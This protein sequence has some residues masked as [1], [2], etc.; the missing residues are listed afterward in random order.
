MIKRIIGLLLCLTLV[1]IPGFVGEL[2]PRS[3][4]NEGYALYFL[5][6]EYE[7]A[8]G[9][10]ALAAERVKVGGEDTQA[11]AEALIQKLLEGPT[12]EGLKR[13]IPSGTSLLSLELQGRRA[14]V[15]LSG[16]YG[17]LSG[18]ALTLADYAITLTLTQL[19]DIQAVEITVRGHEL[20]YREQQIFTA[21]DVLLDPEEDV[22]GTVTV[23][24][25]FPDGT[26]ALVPQ[27]RKLQLYEGDTQA[28]TVVAAL[29]DG[30]EGKELLK[31]FPE[32]FQVRSTWQEE[33]VC[34]VNLSSALLEDYPELESSSI[35]QALTAIGKSLCSLE[36]VSETRFLVDGEF[37]QTYGGVDISPPYN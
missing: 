7:D 6:E 30:P 11:I 22:V 8:A 29:A 20:V 1:L 33:E 26:G 17:S 13:A 24:L 5:V 34:Y 10:G 23:E 16:G 18:I 3:T 28:G 31:V 27:T 12:Q 32:E 35:G 37:I 2:I 15:D 4:A 19:S 21:R 36:T 9:G 25:Y 14:I